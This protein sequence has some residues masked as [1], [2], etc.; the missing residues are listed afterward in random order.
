MSWR[1]TRRPRSSRAA[2]SRRPR[3]ARVRRRV[4]SSLGRSW[5]TRQA[6]GK[7]IIS[8]GTTAVG[9]L[10]QS[11]DTSKGDVLGNVI[12]S[13]T[14]KQDKARLGA[15]RGHDHRLWAGAASTAQGSRQRRRLLHLLGGQGQ[16]RET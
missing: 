13:G 7:Y 6:T 15:R 11:V 1:R 16:D 9:I 14:V 5:T 10:L 12:M 3:R 8:G 4:P 2:P